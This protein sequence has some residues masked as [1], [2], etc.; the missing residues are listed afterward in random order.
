M[1]I[2]LLKNNIQDSIAKKTKRYDDVVGE[3]KR[4]RKERMTHR[5]HIIALFSTHS[6]LLEGS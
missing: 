3:R 4:K 5:G 6:V 2:Q 1:K